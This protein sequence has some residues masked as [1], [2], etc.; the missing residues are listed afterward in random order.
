[1]AK[2]SFP[3]LVEYQQKIEKLYEKSD[4]MLKA[5]VYPGVNVVADAIRKEIGNIPIVDA[6]PL[7]DKENQILGI[8]RTQRDGLLEGLGVSPILNE[9]GIV[10]AKIGFNGYN[11]ATTNTYPKG[12]PNAIIAR[13]IESGTSFRK[14]YPFV[15]KA[16]KASK[17]E[18][19]EA[20]KEAIDAA[21]AAEMNE[22]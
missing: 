13:S 20:I 21:I 5:C 22:V 8:T 14:K 10:N 7:G 6:M 19:E 3:G 2:I 18:A 1:M 9:K 12:Q 11:K 17:A 16:V 4:N 15:D